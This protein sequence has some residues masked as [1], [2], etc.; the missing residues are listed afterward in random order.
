MASKNRNQEVLENLGFEAKEASEALIKAHG[1]FDLALE[2]LTGF[3][4]RT[5]SASESKEEYASDG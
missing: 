3:P 1:E 5:P 2:V 4:S